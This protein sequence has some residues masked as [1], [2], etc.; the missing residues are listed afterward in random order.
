[1][2]QRPIFAALIAVAVTASG[3]AMAQVVYKWVDEKGVTHYAEEPPAGR[4]SRQVDI[5]PSGYIRDAT[6]RADPC[7]T[8]QCQYERVRALRRQDEADQRAESAAQASQ[9]AATPSVRGMSFDTF[10]RLSTGMP[11]GQV[12]LIAGPPDF[13]SSQLFSGYLGKTWFYYPTSSDPFT[14]TIFFTGGTVFSL[15][16]TR[17]FR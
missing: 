14:T 11:D 15:N 1:M 5:T 7:Q 3:S 10:R 4:S 6:S 12:L 13:A 8:V 17:D 16:R 9:A 2:L